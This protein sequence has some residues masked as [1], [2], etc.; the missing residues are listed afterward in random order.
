MLPKGDGIGGTGI[1][2]KPAEK[3]TRQ[4]DVEYKGPAISLLVLMRDHRDA[5]AR[6]YL[7]A[8]FAGHAVQITGRIGFQEMVPAVTGKWFP[9]LLIRILLGGAGS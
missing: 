6:A 8:E 5:V 9:L 1:F 2:A 3:T 7:G 4:V